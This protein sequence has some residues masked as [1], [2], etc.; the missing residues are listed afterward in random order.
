MK[1]LADE[2]NNAYTVKKLSEKQ[3]REVAKILMNNLHV[4]YFIM[5]PNDPI[6]NPDVRVITGSGVEIGKISIA[7]AFKL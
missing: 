7:Q 4:P 3:S 2:L 6:K 5:L 1:S